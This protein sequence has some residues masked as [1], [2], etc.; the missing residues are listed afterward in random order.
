MS[1]LL[2]IEG[3]VKN[4]KGSENGNA[5]EILILSLTFVVSEVYGRGIGMTLTIIEKQGIERSGMT[6]IWL[7]RPQKNRT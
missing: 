2:T 5:G 1:L 7:K 6:F 4:G 3:Y